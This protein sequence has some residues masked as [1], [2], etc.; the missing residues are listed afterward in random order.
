MDYKDCITDCD[1]LKAE[2]DTYRPLDAHMLEQ[3]RAYYRVGL[4]YASNALEGNTLT[5]TETKVVLEDGMTIGGKPMKDHLEA[6]GHAK[7]FDLLDTL[8]QNAAV[9]EADLLDLHRLVVEGI[10]G[11]EPGQYRSKQVI[12][13]GTT[14]LPPQPLAV[15]GQMKTF[16]EEELP[17]WLKTAHPIHA[18]AHAHLA[19][20]TIHPFLD[21]N[22]RTARLLMNLLLLKAGY[23][24]TLVPPILR[25][26]Y[27]AGL[28]AFQENQET[29]PFLNFMSSMVYESSK[30]LLRLLKHLKP[31]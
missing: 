1:A 8:T 23:G 10:E 9:Q 29:Q 22:G 13:T 18:A 25:A 24:V 15:P 2:I 11:T 4:T 31:C 26:D 30:D 21:G 28:R 14:Y 17:Q 6:I 20:V 7:A 5:E 3:L 12:I 27:M 16:L 19:L